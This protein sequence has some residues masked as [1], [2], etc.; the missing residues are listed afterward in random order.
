MTKEQLIAAL[1]DAAKDEM[2]Q[3]FPVLVQRLVDHPNRPDEATVWF[4]AGVARIFEA[5]KI[6]RSVIDAQVA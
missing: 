6:A 4:K 2:S 3:Y 1:D 5:Y